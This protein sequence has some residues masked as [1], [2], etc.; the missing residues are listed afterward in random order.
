MWFR[1]TLRLAMNRPRRFNAP[2]FWHLDLCTLFCPHMPRAGCS[3]VVFY[4]CQEW[5]GLRTVRISGTCLDV[6]NHGSRC[7][8]YEFGQL[9]VTYLL[10]LLHVMIF[11]LNKQHPAPIALSVFSISKLS[12]RTSGG[13]EADASSFLRANRQPIHS[14]SCSKLGTHHT[15]QSVGN[16]SC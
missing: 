7:V 16:Q 12:S 4:L 3:V 9:P 5:A 6:V 14:P 2:Q 10:V 11:S 13:S 8:G 1:I 15:P